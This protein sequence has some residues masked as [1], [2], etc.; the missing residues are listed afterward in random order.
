MTETVTSPTASGT[1]HA[2]FFRQSGWLMVAGVGAGV[3]NWAVHFLN[4]ALP[5]GEYGLFVAMM[6]VATC[7]Q[8]GPLQIVLAQQT[9]QG[10]ATGRARQVSGMIRFLCAGT[11]VCWL[12][13]AA[14]LIVLQ[15]TLLARWET[16]STA[17]FWIMLPIMLLSVWAPLFNGVLQGQQNFLWLGWCSILS[18]A[19]RFSVG[20]V[21]VLAL[22]I[23]AAGIMAGVA[24]AIRPVR[25]APIAETGIPT[26]GGVPVVS[27]LFFRRYNFCERLVPQERG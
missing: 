4:K 6:A 26:G 3:L 5:P 24:P 9:A 10:L 16:T 7:V 14:V 20:A 15:K 25:L 17:G 1:A 13:A 2:S 22:K 11:M 12:V 19:L 8:A 27:A 21:A 18:A 23:Y